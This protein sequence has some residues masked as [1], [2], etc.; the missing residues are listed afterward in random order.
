MARCLV[1]G[2]YGF[3]GGHLV[4]ALVEGGHDV[5]I[6]DNLVS[7]KKESI[8]V[9]VNFIKGDIRDRDLEDMGKFDYVFHLA[10]LPRVQFSIDEPLK[11]HSANLTGTVNI[12]EY[13]RKT[14]AKII[15]SS[16]SAIFKGE[17]LPT[18]EE[19]P[20]N[21]RSP[22]ALQKAM[23]EQYIRLYHYLFGVDYA[24][25]RYFN[26][27]GERASAEGSYPL[28]IALF[29]KQRLEGEP[30]TITNDGSQR[31]D[32]TY[33]KDIARANIL[34]MKWEGEYNLGAGNNYSVNEVASMIGGETKNIGP[35]T[36]EPHATLADNTKALKAGW[37]PRMT[38]K[39]WLN[40]QV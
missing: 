5:T 6:L 15:F 40:G 7:G 31:R 2:G 11:T 25:L 3:I 10:A 16:S 18:K 32:F 33:V 19:D 8:Q 26:V 4:E 27:Y 9:K 29:L 20:L 30:L 1:T 23:S 14:G 34:A 28:V 39:E 22:Y 24:I 35:R 37:E 21:P 13:C 38:L 17:S 36:G 12:L